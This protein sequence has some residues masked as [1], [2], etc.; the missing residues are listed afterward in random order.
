M[1]VFNKFHLF[2]ISKIFTILLW[3]IHYLKSDS[4]EKQTIFSNKVFPK[5]QF[6]KEIA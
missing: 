1:Q 5:I 2:K 3:S 4:E 6:T